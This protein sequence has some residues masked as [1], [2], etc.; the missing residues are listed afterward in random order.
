M[1]PDHMQERLQK[2]IA[3]AG[4]TSR[5][6]AEALIVAGQVTVNGNVITELGAKA[7]SGHDHIRVKGRLLQPEPLEYL[8]LNK[9]RGVISAVSDPE[10]RPVVTDYVKSRF[11]LYPAGRLDFESEGLVLL[12]N[13]GALVRKVT[14]AGVIRKMYRV[15]IS[16]KA[17]EPQLERMRKGLRLE[18]GEVFAPCEIHLFKPGNNVWYQV[19]LKQGRNRQIRRMFEN[20]GCYVLK[21]RRMSIG[22]IELG[23][24]L[25]GQ[26]R[27][28]TERELQRLKR[29]AGAAR[30]KRR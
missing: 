12:T 7:D 28:L 18:S 3:R 20:V 21:L 13:D 26:W 23:S 10:G 4:I 24:L 2:I 30:A 27:H 19:V 1:I 9:P 15:K 17:G 6:K 8:I 16:G 14:V 11:R 29:A 5:R 25:P 22:P